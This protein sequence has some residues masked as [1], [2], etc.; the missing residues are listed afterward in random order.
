VL[1]DS[2]QRTV[3]IVVRVPSEWRDLASED[4]N[5][6]L[7]EV[8]EESLPLGED[9]G[10]GEESG[11]LSL[12]LTTKLLEQV[13]TDA[14][15]ARNAELIRR[16]IALFRPLLEEVQANAANDILV[17]RCTGCRV[18]FLATPWSNARPGNFIYTWARDAAPSG[19]F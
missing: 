1:Q 15:T 12:W 2:V 4:I 5:E 9:P 7:R 6:M 13:R 8:T 11:R 10:C 18:Q 3:H 16:V 14:G 17:A 19:I